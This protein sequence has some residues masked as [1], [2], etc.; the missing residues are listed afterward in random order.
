MP[1]ITGAVDVQ[2]EIA[3]AALLLRVL[4]VITHRCGGLSFSPAD[5]ALPNGSFG[6][7]LVP[8]EDGA[9]VLLFW[10]PMKTTDGSNETTTIAMPDAATP[11]HDDA[12]DRLCL[13]AFTYINGKQEA[14]GR[15]VLV[16]RET[17]REIRK[18]NVSRLGRAPRLG[19]G[20]LYFLEALL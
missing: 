17:E 8:E 9:G 1:D 6:F 5:L 10:I 18:I 19:G 7:T 3:N 13:S 20:Y 15:Y 2:R 12:I 11:D 4:C 16:E 14:D